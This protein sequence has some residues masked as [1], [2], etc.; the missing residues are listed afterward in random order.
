MKNK[1]K[2]GELVGKEKY[3]SVEEVEKIIADIYNDER[4]FV[5]IGI[6]HRIAQALTRLPK[7]ELTKEALENKIKGYLWGRTEEIM[8]CAEDCVKHQCDSGMGT[9]ISFMSEALA[10]AILATR[11]PK[12]VSE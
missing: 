5:G 8:R 4:G 10:D 2:V 7:P 3:M 9:Y 11:L 1:S 12:G 6:V